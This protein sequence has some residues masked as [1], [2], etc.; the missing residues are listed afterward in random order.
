MFV[1]AFKIINGSGLAALIG[2]FNEAFAHG[3]ES[4]RI[5]FIV[6]SMVPYDWTKSSF[7]I[8]IVPNI[9][10]YGGAIDDMLIYLKWKKVGFLYDNPQG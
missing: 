5:P 3:C 6:T 8:R 7:L 4:A 10:I 9:D 1:S 2:P